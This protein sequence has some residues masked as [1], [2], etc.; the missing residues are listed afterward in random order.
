VT[1]P[2]VPTDDTLA[3]PF[4]RMPD[5]ALGLLAETGWGL[6]VESVRRLATERDDTV[7]VTHAGGRHV[8]K[9]AHP[10]D[11]PALLD[12]Q[13]SAMHHAL[14]HD[15]ALPLA[16]L[17]PDLE[18]AV[19]HEVL[20]ADGEPRR[21]RVLSYL[22]GVLLDYAVTSPEQ[23]EAVGRAAGLLS[24]ALVGF[25]HPGS[26]RVLAWDLQ[27]LGSLRPLLVHVADA[28]ARELV[29]AE[30]DAYDDHVGAALRATRQQVIHNDVNVDN[31][32]VDPSDPAFVHGILDFGDAVHGS[33]VGDL[34]VAMSYAAGAAPGADD[35][36]LAAYDLARGFRSVRGLTADETALL[37]ELV[38]ARFAQR[39]LLNSWLAAED[40]ANAHY[41]G[42]AIARTAATY[43][44][45]SATPAPIDRAGD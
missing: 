40:P 13:C 7:L 24:A 29:E 1:E 9:V 33:V 14:A 12:F 41:T 42:R 17:L 31:V 10:L 43:A 11:D 4:A 28:Q 25:A 26:Q 3:A 32:V 19:L 6:Q 21:A 5:A 16:S 18:G 2:G 37:P 20:G 35:P 22:E 45:L 36:W 8:L 34:A 38:R 15:P 44:R 27:Q 23:R 30:L 39:L